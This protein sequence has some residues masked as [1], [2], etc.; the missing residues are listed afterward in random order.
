MNKKQVLW[1]L[2]DLVF[3]IIFNVVFF[4]AGGTEHKASV[5]ISYAF[6]HVAYIMLVITPLLVRKTTNKAVLGFPHSR[7]SGF[8]KRKRE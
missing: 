5:W 6:I 2:L 3:F 1:I 7:A 8:W 4:V